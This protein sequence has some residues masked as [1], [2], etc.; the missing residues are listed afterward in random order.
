YIAKQ[1][2]PHHVISRFTAEGDVAVAG[3]ERVLF[4]GDDQRMLG[5]NIPAG[6]QGGALHFGKDGKLYASIGEQTAEAPAQ[7]LDSLLGKVIRL[8]ADGTIPADNPFVGRTGGKY[9]AIWAIGC[10][11][12]FTFAIR[13]STGKMLIT[14]VR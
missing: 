6:H 12:P 9:A 7:R 4:E 14:D 8:N 11:N 13:R 5:G 10:R 3:S 2:Y 1:A